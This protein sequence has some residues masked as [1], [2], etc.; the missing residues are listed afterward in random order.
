MAVAGVVYMNED[1]QM[2]LGL[3]YLLYSAKFRNIKYAPNGLINEKY[4]TLNRGDK[5]SSYMVY[6]SFHNSVI[7]STSNI[8]I[9]FVD[10]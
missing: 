5:F 4:L 7:Y 9:I 3:F 8:M 1:V 10:F 2:F 6:F